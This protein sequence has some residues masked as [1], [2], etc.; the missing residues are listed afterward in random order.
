MHPIVD[1]IAQKCHD[2]VVH[3]EATPARAIRPMLVR[4]LHID[5]MRLSSACCRTGH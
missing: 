2:R 3:I 5:L 4:R 1:Y